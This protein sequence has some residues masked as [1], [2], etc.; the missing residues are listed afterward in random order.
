MIS[1]RCFIR[2]KTKNHSSVSAKNMHKNVH[3]WSLKNL[4]RG[5]R[6]DQKPPIANIRPVCA[7]ARGGAGSQRFGFCKPAWSQI[8]F[9][10]SVIHRQWGRGQHICF[11]TSEHIHHWSH[12]KKLGQRLG[13]CTVRHRQTWMTGALLI[14]APPSVGLMSSLEGNRKPGFRFL[15]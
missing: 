9:F 7:S 14:T 15:E 6:T 4:L 2:R 5:G 13:L 12:I 11:C 8:Y 3:C 1:F 10:S